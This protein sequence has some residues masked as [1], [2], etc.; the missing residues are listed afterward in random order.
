MN[1]DNTRKCVVYPIHRITTIKELV[2][3][4]NNENIDMLTDNLRNFLIMSK[5]CISLGTEICLAR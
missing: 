3:V 2:E 1:T 5:N 4:A